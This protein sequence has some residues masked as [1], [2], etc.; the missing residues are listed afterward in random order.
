M[1]D[2]INVY[3]VK[4]PDGISEMVAP[5]GIGYTI[6]I[7]ERLTREGQIEAYNHAL[8]HI[9]RADFGSGMDVDG[10]ETDAR[11]VEIST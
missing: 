6:Y 4:L 2:D 8:R 9:K 3:L 5:S 7:E 11:E 10:I 1:N